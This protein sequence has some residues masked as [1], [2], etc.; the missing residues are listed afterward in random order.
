MNKFEFFT[1]WYEREEERRISLE[2]SLNIPI[3]ILTLIYAIQFYLI[4]EF[5]FEGLTSWDAY[6][7]VGLVVLSIVSSI[8]TTYYLFKSYHNTFL[9]FEYKGLPYP[10][11]L[12]THE[13]KLVEYYGQHQ[14]Y[15]GGV[16]GTEKF[17]EYLT[18]KF[19]EL[20]DWNAFNNDTKSRYLHLSKRY[21]FISILMLALSFIPFFMNS[22]SKP[23]KPQKIEIVK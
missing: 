20:L 18:L 14:A 12:L 10:T 1:Q 11:Q 19:A 15:Y 22:M 21:I 7:F 2:S 4:K 13:K 5:Y 8:L 6:F 23:D 9:G 16:T 17:E 3:G